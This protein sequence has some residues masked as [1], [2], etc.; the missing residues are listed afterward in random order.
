MANFNDKD[1]LR[2]NA[3]TFFLFKNMFP[4]SLPKSHNVLE[5]RTLC[6]ELS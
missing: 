4:N 5:Y 1:I 6:S 2:N 3:I